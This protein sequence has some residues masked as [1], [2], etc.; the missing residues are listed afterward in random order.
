MQLIVPIALF[1]L[2]YVCISSILRIGFRPRI[3][4]FIGSALTMSFGG[5]IGLI[6]CRT[7]ASIQFPNGNY[8]SNV[9][10]YD[11]SSWAW[12]LL[13]AAIG[14]ALSV[15]GVAIVLVIESLI[16]K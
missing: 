5:G 7:V 3:A 8:G 14:A 6:V 4:K 15:F 12:C 13:S 16:Q 2:I 1:S 9:V 10:S 11:T